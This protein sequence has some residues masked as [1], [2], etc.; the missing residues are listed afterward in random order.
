MHYSR[1]GATTQ[2]HL[3]LLLCKAMNDNYPF[4]GPTGG[5]TARRCASTANWANNTIIISN[6]NDTFEILTD[7][8]VVALMYMGLYTAK[9]PACSVNDMLQKYSYADYRS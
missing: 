4:P 1:K 5:T 6:A 3:G 2:L 8:Q 7:T 9:V